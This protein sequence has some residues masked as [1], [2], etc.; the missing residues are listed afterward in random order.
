M[1]RI[2]SRLGTAKLTVFRNFGLIF[3]EDLNNLSARKLE[4]KD[5]PLTVINDS[6]RL[7]T[8]E[9]LLDVSSDVAL[10]PRKPDA[11][12]KQTMPINMVPI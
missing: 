11:L 9:A 6:K 8:I 4:K 5:S 12:K 3:F 7:T 1:L 2:V 10:M